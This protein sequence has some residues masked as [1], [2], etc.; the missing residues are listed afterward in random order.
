MKSLGP[1]K[2]ATNP[3]KMWQSNLRVQGHPGKNQVPDLGLVKHILIWATPYVGGLHKDIGRRKIHS[4]SVYIYL[5]AHL[6]EPTFTE[7]QLK[8]LPSWD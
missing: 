1:G 2:Y 4:S 8:Y 3:R 7:D 6:L 5:L